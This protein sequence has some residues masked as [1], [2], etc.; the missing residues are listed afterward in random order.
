M[1][2]MNVNAAVLFILLFYEQMNLVRDSDS[3]HCPLT[4]A[5]VFWSSKEQFEIQSGWAQQ[6]A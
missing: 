1:W 3:F 2:P 5:D 4:S 6:S